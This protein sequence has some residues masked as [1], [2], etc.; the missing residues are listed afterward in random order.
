MREAWAKAQLLD[1][2]GNP[3]PHPSDGDLAEAAWTRR[4]LEKAKQTLPN[5]YCGMP[6]HSPCSH[7]N[8]CLTCPLFI[9]SSEFLPQHHSQLRTTLELI[10]VSKRSGHQRLVDANEKVAA[11]LQRIIA[12]CEADTTGTELA[13]AR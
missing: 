8:A 12:A 4:G 3:L 1:V 10:D 9:T 11:N 6:L 2:Q 7:A 13:D 5:G